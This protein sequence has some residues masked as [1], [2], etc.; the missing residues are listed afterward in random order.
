VA[1]PQDGA[2]VSLGG[3]QRR[4]DAL[5]RRAPRPASDS[6]VH[7]TTGEMRQ[8]LASMFGITV[9]ELGA[10]AREGGIPDLIARLRSRL[11]SVVRP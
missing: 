11:G 3:M 8:R 7:P 1:S 10:L 5:A 9:P 2:P 4:L 6:F